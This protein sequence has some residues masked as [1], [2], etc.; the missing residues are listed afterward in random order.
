MRDP[1]VDQLV[2]QLTAKPPLKDTHLWLG[3]LVCYLIAS[4]SVL[5]LMGLRADYLQA[6]NNGALI[7]KPAIFMGMGLSSLLLITRLSRPH[8][9][10]HTAHGLGGVFA[11]ALMAT[12]FSQQYSVADSGWFINAFS[13]SMNVSK[14]VFC[15][16]TII[17]SGAG[18]MALVWQ[19]WLK[20][21]AS[22]HP[23]AM[24]AL[25]GLGAG[26][27]VSAAF[28]WHCAMDT[29]PY[30]VVYYLFPIG[31]LTGVGFVLGKRLSW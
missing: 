10:V 14:G 20:H 26:S 4:F 2:G 11:L 12:L 31:L 27:L 13:A 29:I 24:G 18:V 25:A 19:R 5:T 30:I 15:S 22:T 6:L 3:A 17:V 1:L 23:Q 28:T 21:S 8:G 9:R 16:S 7:W